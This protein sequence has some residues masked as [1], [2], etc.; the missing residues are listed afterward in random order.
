[1]RLSSTGDHLSCC[2]D[3]PPHC[4]YRPAPRTLCKQTKEGGCF[5]RAL[6]Y[7][8]NRTS[9]TAHTPTSLA[10]VRAWLIFLATMKAALGTILAV[11]SMLLL[12]AVLASVPF[13]L[14]RLRNVPAVQRVLM[15]F[16]FSGWWGPE[17]ERGAD[18][19]ERARDFFSTPTQLPAPKDFCKSLQTITY[20]SSAAVTGDVEAPDQVGGGSRMQH[21]A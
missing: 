13:I 3:D 20:K 19:P 10:G 5:T 7:T 15:A 4:R 6:S 8:S 21:H 9:N 11:L 18:D 17:R 14:H 2:C 16:F 12:V 1:M